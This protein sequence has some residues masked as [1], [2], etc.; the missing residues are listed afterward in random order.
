MEPGDCSGAQCGDEGAEQRVKI[1]VGYLPGGGPCLLRCTRLARGLLHSMLPQ[2]RAAPHEGM[3]GT[4][5]GAG[6]GRD[7]THQGRGGVRGE[8]HARD[9]YPVSAQ[10]ALK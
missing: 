7:R 2:T 4:D 6:G 10:Q 1:L 8:W 5:P 9:R 3:S